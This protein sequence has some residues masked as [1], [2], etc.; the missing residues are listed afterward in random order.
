[1][2]TRNIRRLLFSPSVQ[3]VSLG[4]ELGKLRGR[5]EILLFRRCLGSFAVMLEIVKN[6]F[7]L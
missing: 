7:L 6:V 1:M 5:R 2:N 3:F 4:D